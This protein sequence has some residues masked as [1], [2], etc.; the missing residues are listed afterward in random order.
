[1]TFANFYYL[2]LVVFF[3]LYFITKVQEIRRVRETNTFDHFVKNVSQF[4]NFFLFGKN[5]YKY[6]IFQ[7]R[8]P[9]IYKILQKRQLRL[10][11][12]FDKFILKTRIFI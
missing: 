9:S 3:K 2:I 5:R 8:V 10:E 12:G 11:L 6:N 4:V 7:L 1:M